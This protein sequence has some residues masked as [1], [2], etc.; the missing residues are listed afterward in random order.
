MRYVRSYVLTKKKCIIILTLVGGLFDSQPANEYCFTLSNANVTFSV[1]SNSRY[2][3]ICAII[4]TNFI[5]Y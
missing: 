1:G 2:V 5:Q 4:V 3:V